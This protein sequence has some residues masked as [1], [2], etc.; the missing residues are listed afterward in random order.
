MISKNG[1][2]STPN[3]ATLEP[4]TESYELH[5]ILLA[6]PI[7]DP[8]DLS[9]RVEFAFE[10]LKLHPAGQAQSNQPT[11]SVNLITNQLSLTFPSYH[12]F[13]YLIQSSEDLKTW[14]T[15]NPTS[16]LSGTGSPLFFTAPMS[17]TKQFYR[18]GILP[19]F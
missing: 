9:D 18:L 5:T 11:L 12:G 6:G 1:V 3:C 13:Q 10:H 14:T 16:P 19:G 7:A 2:H 4:A 15:E 17:A 8:N